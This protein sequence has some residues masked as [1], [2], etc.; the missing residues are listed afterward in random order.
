MPK[1]SSYPAVYFQLMLVG[2]S[3][4]MGMGLSA[5]FLPLLSLELDPTG[6]LV[7]FVTSAWFVARIFVEMPSGFLS[8]RIGRRR[9]LVLGLAVSVV[10]TFTCAT[11]RS[12]HQLIFG[13]ALWG[14]G[15]ALF[16]TNNIALVLDMF[17][18]R[19]RGTALGT[20]QSLEF[21]GS[22]IG[23]PL[24]AVIAANFGYYVTFYIATLMTSLSFLIAFLSKGL[25]QVAG[26]P[27]EDHV[28]VPVRKALHSMRNWGLIVVC[29]GVMSRM[30][31][32][33]GIKSTVFQLYLNQIL[34]YD[35]TTIGI[36]ITARTAT[37]SIAT[38]LSGRLIDR[39][40]SK[41]VLIMGLL[42]EGSCIYVY[43]VVNTL[44][45][46]ISIALVEGFGSA[47]ISVTL[48]ILLSEV[49]DAKVRGTAVGFYRTFMDFGG[50]LGPVLF[51][52]AY[53]SIGVRTPFMIGGALLLANIA[54]V[55]TMREQHASDTARG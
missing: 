19:V 20:F 53:E 21:I 43:T 3:L 33:Q 25:K 27:S 13:R 48:I 2:F 42:L 1:I 45:G 52:F 55:I 17:E 28:A 6:V 44:V 10:G 11:S 24:G 29:T 18:P 54:L 40:G 41:P 15:A 9:L 31:I 46:L 49:V 38:L 16:F 7:G 35:I 14:L 22:F 36:I 39:L 50:I 32:E 8:D 12:I 34:S 4:I 23:A 47:T 5:S 51:M 26:K 37:F 30:L